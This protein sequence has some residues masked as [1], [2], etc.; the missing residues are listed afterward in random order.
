[1]LLF[2]CK[3]D[4]RA[5]TRRKGIMWFLWVSCSRLYPYC[6]VEYLFIRGRFETVGVAVCAANSSKGANTRPVMSGVTR[7]RFQNTAVNKVKVSHFAG[8]RFVFMSWT[9]HGWSNFSK[10]TSNLYGWVFFV[11]FV[12]NFLNL[13]RWDSVRVA[14]SNSI[15]HFFHVFVIDFLKNSGVFTQE[16]KYFW[17]RIFKCSFREQARTQY[18]ANANPQLQV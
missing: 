6:S 9:V 18:L 3:S 14:F 11:V 17:S 5:V 12:F 16:W 1:M 2:S 7:Q 4:Q 10:Q 13:T 15:L 8:R